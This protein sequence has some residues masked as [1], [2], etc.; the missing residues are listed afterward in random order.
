MNECKIIWDFK[1]AC[2]YWKPI[3]WKVSDVI[4]NFNSECRYNISLK[5]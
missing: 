1:D 2:D 3:T 5:W 4:G